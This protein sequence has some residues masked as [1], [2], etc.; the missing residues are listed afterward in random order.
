MKARFDTGKTDDDIILIIET[1]TREDQI[2]AHHF[3][4]QKDEKFRV[5]VCGSF[6]GDNGGIDGLHF[7]QTEA[8]TKIRNDHDN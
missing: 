8:A 3:L 2:L 4:K 6:T 7:Y 1:E 5:S